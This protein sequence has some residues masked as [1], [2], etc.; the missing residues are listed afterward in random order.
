MTEEEYAA[1]WADYDRRLA[2]WREKWLQPAV[3]PHSR[4]PAP[5]RPMISRAHVREAAGAAYLEARAAGQQHGDCTGAAVR[6][7]MALEPRWSA[8]DALSHFMR[9]VLPTL[10]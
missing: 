5:E 1:L 2:E 6:A 7:T 8:S 4:E 3:A 10:P 9:M